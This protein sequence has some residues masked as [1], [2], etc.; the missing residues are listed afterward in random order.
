MVFGGFFGSVAGKGVQ[1][2]GY[3]ADSG[4]GSLAGGGVGAAQQVTALVVD[5]AGTLYAGG[6]F[7]GAGGTSTNYVAWWANAWGTLK[8]GTMTFTSNLGVQSLAF[9]Q[10]GTLMIGGSFNGAAGSTSRNLVEW[11]NDA[12]GTLK[13]QQGGT[14]DGMVWALTVGLNN[15]LFFGGA[16]G[17]AGGTAT[18]HIGQWFGSFGSMTSGV[19]QEVLG[20]ATMLDGRI[21]PAGRF[22]TAGGGSALTMAF[23]NGVQFAPLGGGITNG[24]P[25]T[26]F[27]RNDNSL[28]VSGY[29]SQVGSVPTPSGAVIWNGFTFLPFD[30][31][32]TIPGG[33]AGIWDFTQTPDGTVWA[34]GDFF[35]S[36]KA[37]SV[38]QIVNTGRSAV[39]PTMRLRNLSSGTAQVYQLVNGVSNDGIYF[40]LA[41]LPQEQVTLTLKPGA[42][43][44]TSNVRGNLLR[45]V[46]PGSNLATFNLAPGTNYISFFA[47]NDSLEASF[48]WQPKGWSI[49]SG[50]V[51]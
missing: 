10:T 5:P 34:G 35:G 51:F 20:L 31:A 19:N 21:A 50:T 32:V 39:Y 37:A 38:T 17:S 15:R 26:A 12:Y 7:V 22:T 27:V 13:G 1:G 6:N 45:S 25:V 28:L 3:Y 36:A 11:F 49:D 47:D 43:A 41:M 46:V 48:F 4:L 2:I 18:T 8:G 14:I 9:N 40:N 29:I 24:L 23:W 42:R 44:L 33:G 30:I 16:F